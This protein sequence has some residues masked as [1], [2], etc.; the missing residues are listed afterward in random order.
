MFHRNRLFFIMELSVV[1]VNYN[2]RFFLEQCLNSV[3]KAIKGLD[4]E[5]FVVDNNSVDGSCS[6]VHEKFP[7]VIFIENK[8]NLGFSKAN[9]QAIRLA[10]GKYVL[11]LNPDTVVQEDSFLKTV[12]FMESHPEAGGLGVKMIDGKGKF[13]PESKRGLPTPG[14]AFCKIFG[15]SAL[16]PK[17]KIFGKYHLGYLNNEQIHEIAVLSGAF[18]LMRA[19]TLQKS[20]LLDEAFFMYGEDIDLSY[21]INLAGYKNYYFPNTT[22][23]HYKGEST[24]KGSI[25]YVKVFYNAMI[26][27]ARKHFSSRNAR[28]YEILITLAIYFRAALAI[29]NRFARKA[30]LPF[31]DALLIFT[32]FYLI[33]PIWENYKFTDGSS[34]PIEYLSIVVPS[35]LVI[36]LLSLFFAGAYDKP[37]KVKEIIKGLGMGTLAILL[38]YSLLPEHLRFSRM[39]ILL[40]TGWS[41]FVLL[42]YRYLLHFSFKSLFQFHSVVRK[43]IAI[44]GQRTEIERVKQLLE[45]TGVNSVFIGSIMPG[46]QKADDYFIGNCSQLEDI[47]DINHVDELIF[48]ASNLQANEIID[49]MLALAGKNIDFKIAQP[50]SI[51]IVGSNSIHTAGDLYA[52]NINSINSPKNRR[53][54]SVFD[55]SFSVFVLLSYPLLFWV[56][57]KPAGCFRNIF[58]VL[59]GLKSWVGF[60]I[61]DEK[62][63]MQLPKI[64]PGVLSPISGMAESKHPEVA[65]W[66]NQNYAKDYGWANELMI[67]TRAFSKLGD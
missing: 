59:F 1:I 35:Y 16:F 51:S 50:D 14:V 8:Q 28:I 56:Y 21:R 52:V 31:F 58:K 27:F 4:A 32:G 64:R 11:L 12:E 5:V 39:M 18:M 37:Y 48:C 10:K 34:Y 62:A 61:P 22:I 7:W 15:L 65:R 66:A 47:V 45:Q 49:Y 6:M 26:I 55:I 46:N 33:K 2:V 20:G 57:E 41:L 36:W 54:K 53:K 44:I 67:V 43:R 23:I 63:A 17:S 40:G 30:F 38:I 60:Y 19:E 3:E 25:N 24:K 9:N 29:L 13:L 42:L